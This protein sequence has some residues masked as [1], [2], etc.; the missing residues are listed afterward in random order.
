MIASSLVYC[1]MT[2]FRRVAWVRTTPNSC[3]PIQGL[4]QVTL[5]VDGLLVGCPRIVVN[6]SDREIDQRDGERLH[7]PESQHAIEGTQALRSC[8]ACSN[9]CDGQCD[10]QQVGRYADRVRMHEV[11]RSTKFVRLRGMD[12]A[13][14]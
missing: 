5:P 2:T 13:Q 1:L 8:K 9:K 11:D 6:Q 7:E 4:P 10:H 14:A 3:R 12:E